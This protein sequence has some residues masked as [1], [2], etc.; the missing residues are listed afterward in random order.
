MCVCARERERRACGGGASHVEVGTGRGESHKLPEA[1]D[2][3]S[4]EEGR[5]GEEKEL[6][7]ARQILMHL[8]FEVGAEGLRQPG[9][10]D[11]TPA[12]QLEEGPPPCVG[13]D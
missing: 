5:V 9:R 13:S 11:Y 8:E 6:T 3:R 12:V 10:L 4:S 1:F 7:R 2:A